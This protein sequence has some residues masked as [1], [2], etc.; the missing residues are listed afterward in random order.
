MEEAKKWWESRTV[1][2]GILTS[3]CAILKT[4]GLLP[5]T[6]DHSILDEIVTLGLGLATIYYRI[7]AVKQVAVVPPVVAK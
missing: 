4:L 6:F 3:L 7:M 5:E 2:M 1:W